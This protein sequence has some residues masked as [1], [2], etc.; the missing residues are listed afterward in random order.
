MANVEEEKEEFGWQ[1]NCGW[2]RF[3]QKR[4]P[5]MI[6]RSGTVVP[7]RIRTCGQ[8]RNVEGGRSWSEWSSSGE[9]EDK[10][11]AHKA[12][13]ARLTELRE[14]RDNVKWYESEGTKQW[15]KAEPSSEEGRYEENEK[16]EMD[17]EIDRKK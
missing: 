8:D 4:S 9:C 7:A 15:A 6:A 16:M 1:F 5:L 11:L 13:W 10:V 2:K 3:V 17:E 14:L 12:Q